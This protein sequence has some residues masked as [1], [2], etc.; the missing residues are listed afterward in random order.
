MNNNFN[1][2]YDDQL[3]IIT[4]T[5]KS[6]VDPTNFKE[7]MAKTRHSISS[8]VV[9]GIKISV[10]VDMTQWKPNPD[11]ERSNQNV[12]MARKLCENLMNVTPVI[13]YVAYIIKEDSHRLVI[14]KCH[15]QSD[16]CDRVVYVDKIQDAHK[17][18]EQRRADKKGN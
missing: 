14:D 8:L 12:E 17:W 1:F 18:I 9:Q 2:D 16:T 10:I 5:L 3:Q 6:A 4:V 11:K 13:E 7:L 15:T